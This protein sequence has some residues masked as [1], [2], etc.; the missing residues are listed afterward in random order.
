M[1]DCSM[2]YMGSKR[3]ML[4]NGL[5]DLIRE[6]AKS[7]K[8]VVDLFCGSAAVSWFAA[9]NTGC[10]V[11]SVDLQ[12][13]SA[14]LARAVVTRTRAVNPQKCAREWLQRAARSGLSNEFWFDAFH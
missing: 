6:K 1:G 4:Q 5:G 12:T 9:E 14:I 13:Y 2:K 7:A 8:R 3:A 10:P 11:L